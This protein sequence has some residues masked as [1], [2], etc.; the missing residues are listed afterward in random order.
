MKILIEDGSP[1]SKGRIPITHDITPEGIIA[2]VDPVSYGALLSSAGNY[3]PLE[4]VA[5]YMLE[6]AKESS[7][8]V[9]DE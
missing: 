2:R 1:L 5:V 8:Q 7:P 9:H 4:E 6:L 3:F